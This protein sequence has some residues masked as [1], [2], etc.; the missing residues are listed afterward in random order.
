MEA[1]VNSIV[2]YLRY[3]RQQYGAEPEMFSFNEANIGVDV[4]LTPEEHRDIDQAA[5]RGVRKSGSQDPAAPGR[6]HRL[7][8]HP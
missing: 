8:Q 6:R 2:S 5:G 4:L 3:A 1:L 7:A